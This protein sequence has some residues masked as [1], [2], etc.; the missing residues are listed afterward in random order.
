MDPLKGKHELEI[1]GSLHFLKMAQE[2]DKQTSCTWAASNGQV[3]ERDGKPV[4]LTIISWLSLLLGPLTGFF[5]WIVSN[6][7]GS[8]TGPNPPNNGAPPKRG[9]G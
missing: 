9:L 6:T 8:P 7:C 1:Q 5:R 3:H 2:G 4:I